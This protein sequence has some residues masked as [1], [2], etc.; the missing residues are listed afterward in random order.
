M[1]Y[2]LVNAYSEKVKEMKLKMK[3][4]ALLP[5][6]KSKNPLDK[7]DCKYIQI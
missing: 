3:K 2:I 7:L 4:E 1:N 5:R 6:V